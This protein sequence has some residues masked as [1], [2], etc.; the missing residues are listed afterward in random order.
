MNL[1]E[2]PESVYNLDEIETSVNSEPSKR[3]DLE[4]L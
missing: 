3:P 4:I 2:N 1:D